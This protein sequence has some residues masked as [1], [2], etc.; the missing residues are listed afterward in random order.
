MKTKHRMGAHAKR[1]HQ[2]DHLAWVRTIAGCSEQPPE[3]ADRIMLLMR[4]AFEK[5]KMG[6]DDEQFDRLAAAFN[7]GLI[8]AEMIDPLAAQ[9]MAM[10]LDA[11]LSADGIRIRHGRYG[12]N[13]PDLPAMADALELYEGILRMSTPKQMMDALSIAAERMR[14]G[15]VRVSL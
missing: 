9:T 2:P 6:G 4:L 10:G 11:L 7:V 13:G 5:L 15:D 12:F 8:R 1:R 3:N 14:R